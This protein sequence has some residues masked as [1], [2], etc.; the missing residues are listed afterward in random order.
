[1][2]SHRNLGWL[3]VSV[4]SLLGFAWIAGPA[5]AA[6]AIIVGNTTTDIDN[7]PGSN[8]ISDPHTIANNQNRLLVVTLAG[9]ANLGGSPAVNSVAAAKKLRVRRPLDYYSSEGT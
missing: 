9:E 3:S 8:T 6:A 5:P 7:S 2:G 4:L 1:M